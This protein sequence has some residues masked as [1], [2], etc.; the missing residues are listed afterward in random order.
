[1]NP[2]FLFISFQNSSCLDQMTQKINN[3]M[4]IC[5]LSI[6]VP[7]NLI[8]MV[9]FASLINKSKTN[10]GL[11][12]TLQCIVDLFVA[13]WIQFATRYSDYASFVFT[14]AEVNEP[15]CKV[16]MF[17]RRVSVHMSSWMVL[18]STLDRFLF[19]FKKRG[20]EFLRRKLVL[21]SFILLTFILLCLVNILNLF[22]YLNSDGYC[23][24]SFEILLTSDIISIIFRTYLPFCLMFYLNVKMIRTISKRSLLR[25]ENETQKS[26]QSKTQRH[27]EH[28]F[29]VAV[30]SSDLI[31]FITHL[32]ITIVGIL[33]DFWTYP[34]LNDGVEENSSQQSVYDFILMISMNISYLDKAFSI[35]FYLAFNK[36][37]RAQFVVFVAKCLPM[38]IQNYKN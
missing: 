25:I 33:Y 32:P 11:L 28:C 14:L 22:F 3:I 10:M 20:C 18:I 5:I 19:I 26:L 29:T 6:G 37:F 16:S 35:F 9:I 17:F 7:S 36:I 34:S 23:A 1:M 27:K 38:S 2:S 31:F 8:S 15:L 30:I 24:A 21:G 4:S 13:I 12:Y